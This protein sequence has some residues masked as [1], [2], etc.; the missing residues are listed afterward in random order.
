MWDI[1]VLI[2]RLD[3]ETK[4]K[5][6]TGILGYRHISVMIYDLYGSVVKGTSW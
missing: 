6:S 3:Q 1:V 2:G 5:L 4:K